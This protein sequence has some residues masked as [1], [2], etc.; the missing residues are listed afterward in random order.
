MGLDRYRTTIESAGLRIVR[1]KEN[2]EYR[3]SPDPRS[4]QVASM[5]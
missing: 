1:V 2:S 5:G 4:G 3:F